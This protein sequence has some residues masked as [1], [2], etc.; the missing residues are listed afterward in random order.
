MILANINSAS[1]NH[2]V[3]KE[4]ALVNV[5]M[6]KPYLIALLKVSSCRWIGNSPAYKFGS[7]LA[8]DARPG[9]AHLAVAMRKGGRGG[10]V[11]VR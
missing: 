1:P 7:K 6:C 5:C 9:T 10:G 11:I 3:L 2:V 4:G 8:E